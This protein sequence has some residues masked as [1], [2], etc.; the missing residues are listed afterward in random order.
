MDVNEGAP[1]PIDSRAGFRAALLWGFQSAFDEDAR[2]IV[3]VDPD[4]AE[5]PW[6]D[7]GLLVGLTA[8]LKRPQRRLVLLA[9]RDDVLPRRCPRFDKWRAD[10]THAVEGRLAPEEAA[11]DLPVLLCS[12]RRASV[13]LLDAEHWRGRSAL[14]ARAALLWLQALEPVLQR[15]Q[16]GFS[17]RTLGL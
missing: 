4:F 6:D 10:W 13:Q 14:D 11:A 2:R 5:W 7:A 12:D 15:S 17:V 3:C 16:P 9:A 1:P 8:W